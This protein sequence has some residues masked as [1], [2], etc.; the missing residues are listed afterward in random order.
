MPAFEKVRKYKTDLEYNQVFSSVPLSE[1]R[2]QHI[3]TEILI[4]IVPP[5]PKIITSDLLAIS[6]KAM[7][8]ILFY[9]AFSGKRC[10]YQT[11]G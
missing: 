4:D 1:W 2:I 5:P 10:H 8:V 3:A 9:V 7:Q 11:Q 6:L